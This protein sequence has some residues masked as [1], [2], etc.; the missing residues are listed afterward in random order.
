MRTSTAPARATSAGDIKVSVMRTVIIRRVLAYFEDSTAGFA[1]TNRFPSTREHLLEGNTSASSH[2]CSVIAG[3]RKLRPEIVNTARIGRYASKTDS[4]SKLYGYSQRPRDGRA[5]VALVDCTQI[6]Q[7]IR[8]IRK[9][10]TERS[11]VQ[12]SVVSR[13]TVLC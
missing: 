3:S 9:S 7:L 8:E 4:S 2:A 5:S 1:R 12:N 11:L 13:L 6:G 10:M